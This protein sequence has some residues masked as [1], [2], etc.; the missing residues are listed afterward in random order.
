MRAEIKM[1]NSVNLNVSKA[2]M[3]SLGACNSSKFFCDLCSGKGYA[4]S[5]VSNFI[6]D[7]HMCQLGSI[8]VALLVGTSLLSIA[9]A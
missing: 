2:T 7:W 1:L 6:I 5:E 3:A 9:Q 4:T 8:R